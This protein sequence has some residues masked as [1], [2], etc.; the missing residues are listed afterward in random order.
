MITQVDLKE[1][2][3]LRRAADRIGHKDPVTAILFDNLAWMLEN[4]CTWLE[5]M[6]DVQVKE[7]G[8]DHV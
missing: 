1:A 7:T 2:R 5:L 3:E 8:G 6:Q 4:G